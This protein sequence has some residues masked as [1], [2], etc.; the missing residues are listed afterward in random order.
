MITYTITRRAYPDPKALPAEA[1]NPEWDQAL[2]AAVP[3]LDLVSHTPPT[4][5]QRPYLTIRIRCSPAVEF[6]IREHL[7]EG[8]LVGLDPENFR[9]WEKH[10]QSTG[11]TPQQ[12][13]ERRGRP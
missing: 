5:S 7:G 9:L 2:L 8:F 1:I 4:A 11:L 10:I 6:E 12:Y 3:G 13:I